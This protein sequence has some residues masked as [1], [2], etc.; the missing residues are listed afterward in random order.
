MLAKPK[1]ETV[2]ERLVRAREAA[3]LSTAQLA[4]R[5]GVRTRTLQSW[6][7][8]RAEPR[9]NRLVMMAGF[10]NVSPTWLLVGQGAAP[11][12]GRSELALVKAELSQLKAAHARSGKIIERLETHVANLAAEASAELR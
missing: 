3:G 5:L 1:Q 8:G 10:L 9:A 6:E 7:D 2:A 4:R 12:E 11:V